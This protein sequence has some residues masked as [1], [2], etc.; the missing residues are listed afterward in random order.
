[1]ESLY[2]LDS[3]EECQWQGQP[4]TVYSHRSPPAP[5]AAGEQAAGRWLELV[6]GRVWAEGQLPACDASPTVGSSPPGTELQKGLWKKKQ[7]NSSLA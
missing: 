1:M 2:Q 5:G 4:A 7:E 6:L 3:P